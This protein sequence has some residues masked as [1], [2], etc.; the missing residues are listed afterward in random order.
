MRGFVLGALIAT[1]LANLG[2]QGANGFRVLAVARH[3]SGS[4]T[5]C[6]CAVCI[7]GDAARHHL[8]VFF[9]QARCKALVAR[10]CARQASLNTTLVRGLGV[11]HWKLLDFVGRGRVFCEIQRNGL[12]GRTIFCRCVP[13]AL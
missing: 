9:L 11:V 12:R 4:E 10:R 6:G 5:A 1:G 8:H 13:S 2:A 3:R 7:Q